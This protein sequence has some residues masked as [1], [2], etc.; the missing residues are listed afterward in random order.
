V[1]LYDIDDLEAVVRENTK[2]R[3]Q[4]LS[5]CNAIIDGRV[6]E[7]MDKLESFPGKKAPAA[8]EALPGWIMGG[9]P[10]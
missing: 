4:E 5:F 8:V 6:A 7:L 3:E 2:N 1:F 9:V 10:A